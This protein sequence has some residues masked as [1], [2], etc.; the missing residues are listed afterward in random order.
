MKEGGSST[1][2]GKRVSRLVFAPSGNIASNL[3]LGHLFS[4][5]KVLGICLGAGGSVGSTGSE[6]GTNIRAR[7]I[8]PSA[9]TVGSKRLLAGFGAGI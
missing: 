7:G 5:I 9:M 6:V 3:S 4:R 8:A 1:G 2:L